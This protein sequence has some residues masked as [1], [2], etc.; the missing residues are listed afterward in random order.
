MFSS[1]WQ[2]PEK[3]PKIDKK[4]KLV[5][6]SII[7]QYNN[8][9]M[10]YSDDES[11]LYKCKKIS[12]AQEFFIRKFK[13]VD[14]YDDVLTGFYTALKANKQLKKLTQQQSS[15]NGGNSSGDGSMPVML[16]YA[17][18]FCDFEE[19]HHSLCLVFPCVKPVERSDI[20][21]DSLLNNKSVSGSTSNNNN[22]SNSYVQQQQQ[23]QQNSS[24]SSPHGNYRAIKLCSTLVNAVAH[25]H[26]T[27]GI[28][29]GNLSWKNTM[30]IDVDQVV[31]G[32]VR[33]SKQAIKH[34]KF[35][36]IAPVR[37]MQ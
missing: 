19:G 6:T 22:N 14:H 17:D 3:P 2:Q 32:D 28:V 36:T 1:F 5:F 25:V 33:Y 21:F 9:S 8:L 23:Q 27:T 7:A 35:T 30:V 29:H 13:Q 31:L 12:T 16:S 4:T 10:L 18:Y 24:S 20:G 37:T 11:T 26:A 34:S 15:G